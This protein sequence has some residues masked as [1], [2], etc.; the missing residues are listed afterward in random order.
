MTET[1]FRLSLAVFAV[2]TTLLLFGHVDQEVW[3][4]VVLGNA[5]IY[6]GGNI[7]AT[8]AHGRKQ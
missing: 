1:K 3:Q 7:G 2:T 4:A 8:F 6:A 5:F